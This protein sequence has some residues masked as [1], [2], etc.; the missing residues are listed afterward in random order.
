MSDLLIRL[1][2][3]FEASLEGRPMTHFRTTKVQALLVYLVTEPSV[4][5]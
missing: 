2:G 5:H 4:A 3:P 1:F